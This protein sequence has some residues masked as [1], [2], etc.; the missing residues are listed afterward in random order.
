MNEIFNQA[1]KV[2]RSYDRL[3][4][5]LEEDS[6]ALYHQRIVKQFQRDLDKNYLKF[7]LLARGSAI[8]FLTLALIHHHAGVVTRKVVGTFLVHE[9]KTRLENYLYD[10]LEPMT[11]EEGDFFPEL[12]ELMVSWNT[13]REAVDKIFE[14]LE[15]QMRRRDLERSVLLV[16]A[17]VE[18]S[19][20]DV[21]SFIRT[22]LPYY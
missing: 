20:Y 4:E 7:Y 10:F 2:V 12:D 1:L 17:L 9:V 19:L 5:V 14:L 15:V 6:S 16:S 13:H 22:S 21:E 3:E 18:M 11:D 8:P